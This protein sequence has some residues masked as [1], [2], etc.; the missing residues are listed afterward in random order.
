MGQAE[1]EHRK[2]LYW[3]TFPSQYN[4]NSSHLDSYRMVSMNYVENYTRDTAGFPRGAWVAVFER[5]PKYGV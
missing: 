3:E 1:Y 5:E 2:V 4:L